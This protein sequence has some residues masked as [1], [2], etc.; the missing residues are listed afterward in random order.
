MKKA[1]NVIISFALFFVL[2]SFFNTEQA[3]AAKWNSRTPYVGQ[4]KTVTVKIHKSKLKRQYQQAKITNKTVEAVNEFISGYLG[5]KA[6]SSLQGGLIGIGT[7]TLSKLIGLG[8]KEQ[9]KETKAILEKMKKNQANYI[10]VKQKYRYSYYSGAG[11]GWYPA[12]KADI[13][14]SK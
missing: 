3:S 9:M 5:Y 2:L 6:K 13:S 14:Y 11:T 4:V 1:A 7:Y 12:G 8:S 10:I